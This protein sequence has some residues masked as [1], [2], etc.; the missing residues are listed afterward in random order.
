MS[1]LSIVSVI[2]ARPQFIKAAIVSRALKLEGIDEKIVHTGQHYDDAMSGR[3]LSELGIDN[4]SINLAVGAG[5]HAAQTAKMMIGFDHYL[6]NLTKRPDAI[7]VYGDTNSTIAAGLVVSKIGIPLIHVEAGLRSYN[8]TMP[9]EVNRVVVDHLSDLLFCSSQEGVKNLRQEGVSAPVIDVGDVM[10][11]AYLHFS[12]EI[13]G[14]KVST[15][16]ED[17]KDGF[18]L[19][20]LHRPGNT[21]EP[22]RFTAIVRALGEL[23]RPCVWPVHPRAKASLAALH[24]PG[25]VMCIDPLGYFD[26]LRALRSCSYVITDSGG[27]QKEA[28]W[29]QR[30]CIT[31]RPETEWVETLEG[32]WNKLCDPESESI[33]QSMESRPTSP[34]GLLYGDGQASRRIATGIIDF[35]SCR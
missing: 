16:F 30:P 25:N 17:L 3:F 28:H 35:F 21:D 23:D 11:D 26:M 31:I 33:A 10:L 27:L 14:R 18:A 13:D 22:A 8:R 2:G 7:V 20:T 5:G 15:I 32:G 24:L 4:V 12:A 34:W 19:V 1:A 6:A 9:E 29:A